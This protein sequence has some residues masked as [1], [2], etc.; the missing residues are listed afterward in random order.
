MLQRPPVEG[1]RLVHVVESRIGITEL[2]V[3][4]GCERLLRLDGVVGGN[5]RVE[6]GELVMALHQL[7]GGA[8]VAG[9]YF[10]SMDRVAERLVYIAEREVRHARNLQRA[11]VVR[12]EPERRGG[13]RIRRHFVADGQRDFAK[14]CQE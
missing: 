13:E 9:F 4:L 6:I 5:G 11:R 12:I 7:Q 3:N 1:D 14:H 2:R 10:V 8:R